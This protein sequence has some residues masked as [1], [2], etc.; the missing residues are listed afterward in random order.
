MSVFK[1]FPVT[2]SSLIQFRAEFFN[3]TNTPTFGIPS[4]TVDTGS[5]GVVT[6]TANNPRQLQFALKYNF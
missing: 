1:E 5:G 2:E 3:I 6:S 4:T